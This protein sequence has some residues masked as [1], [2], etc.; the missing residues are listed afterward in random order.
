MKK[1]YFNIFMRS[2]RLRKKNK[3]NFFFIGPLFLIKI[4]YFYFLKISFFKMLIKFMKDK[5]NFFKKFK[6]ILWKI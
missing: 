6:Q 2:L 5:I 1:V 4:I 3:Q